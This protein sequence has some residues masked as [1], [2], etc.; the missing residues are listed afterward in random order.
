MLLLLALRCLSSLCSS[1][2]IHGFVNQCSALR[3]WSLRPWQSQWVC[4]GGLDHLPAG[5]L[6][7]LW[8]RRSCR[9][10]NANCCPLRK[11][12]T[13][14]RKSWKSTQEDRYVHRI[15]NDH[16]KVYNHDITA[17]KKKS[18]IVILTHINRG[19]V[20]IDDQS[21]TDR[22]EGTMWEQLT[23]RLYVKDVCR[24]PVQVCLKACF[25]N[26]GYNT[27]TGASGNSS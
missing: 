6:W 3:L 9:V 20:W 15:H 21:L 7:S 12:S 10:T 13:N 14:L 2:F 18:I 26:Y 17:F 8:R 27:Q 11:E 24:V 5:V 19:S 1:A 23:H 4:C 25:S 16:S 22:D